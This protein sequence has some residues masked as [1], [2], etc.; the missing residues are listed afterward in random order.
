MVPACLE[1]LR[2]LSVTSAVVEHPEV[3]CSSRSLWASW[4][5]ADLWW[6]LPAVSP[7]FLVGKPACLLE[8]LNPLLPC[9]VHGRG[10]GNRLIAFLDSITGNTPLALE[11]ALPPE[12]RCYG[13]GLAEL[14]NHIVRP[15]NR[16]SIHFQCVDDLFQA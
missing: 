5:A 13:A 11:A 6:H 12:L 14:C 4:E 1:E 9:H 7:A 16:V 3:P 8:H 2:F 15:V 10:H